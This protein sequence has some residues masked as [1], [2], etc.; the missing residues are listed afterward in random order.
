M[1]KFEP[2]HK[3]RCKENMYVH[4]YAQAW[5]SF[6]LYVQYLEYKNDSIFGSMGLQTGP[7]LQQLKDY[8][9]SCGQLANFGR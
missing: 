2:F 7:S 3:Q 8:E 1:K 5:V 6:F 4:N 9:A